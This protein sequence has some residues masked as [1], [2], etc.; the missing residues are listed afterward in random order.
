MNTDNVLN[1]GKRARSE[2]DANR[3]LAASSANPWTVGT[4]PAQSAQGQSWNSTVKQ[5]ITYEGDESEDI[6]PHNG[7]LKDM[8]IGAGMALAAVVAGVYVARFFI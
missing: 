6:P 5:S 2:I 1:A 3:A 7:V 8:L 4:A